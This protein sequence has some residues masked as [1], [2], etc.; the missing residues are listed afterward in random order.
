MANSATATRGPS[1][2]GERALAPDLARG[3]MLLLI[4]LANTS[5]YLWGANRTADSVHPA[6]GSLLDRI[7]QFAIIT[8]V[9]MRVYP[10]FAFLFGYGIVQLLDR[11][12]RAGVPEGTARA[13]LKRRHWWM[14]AI[15]GCHALLLWMGDIIGVY[16]AVGLVM[17]WLFVRRTDR[18]LLVWSAVLVGVLVVLS[19]LS[20]AG[21]VGM[22][23][24]GAAP[25]SGGEADLLG[26]NIS[27]PDYVATLLPRVGVWLLLLV[28]QGFLMLT[29]PAAVLLAFWAARRKILEQP[30]RHLRLLRTTAVGGILIGWLVGLPY[31][32]YHVGVLDV[33]DSAAWAFSL[34]NIASG[35]FAGLGYVALFALIAHWLTVRRGAA[36]AGPR[37][38]TGNGNTGHRNTE[39]GPLVTAIAAVGKRSMSAYLAQSVLCAP[40][41][42]AWGLG[43]GGWF[44]SWQMAA[45]AVAVWLITLA[46]AYA[47]EIRGRRGPAEVLLRRL[48]YRT[49]TRTP[50]RA[51]TPPS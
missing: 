41:L 18:T 44:G 14:I 43:L 12:Q 46:G 49:P 2:V 45:F 38:S 5:W 7:T 34:P 40:L 22:A 16:G 48:A 23:A 9:D 15:G 42:A 25:Q 31:A 27:N 6:D 26:A 36:A 35:L 8:G 17:C 13:L 33:P 1:A 24:A 10:M 32:L 3:F 11:Q 39:H 29:V 20:V 19:L 50:T 51:A 28:A 30:H 21:G 47:L 37:G 4:A